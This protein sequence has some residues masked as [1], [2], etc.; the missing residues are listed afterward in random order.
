MKEKELNL[1]LYRKVYLIRRAED[2]IRANYASD[3]MKTPNR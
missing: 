3:K 2:G 1:S